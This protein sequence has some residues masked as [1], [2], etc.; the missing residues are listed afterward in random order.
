MD[1]EKDIKRK[2]DLR[3]FAIENMG[4]SVKNDA[5]CNQTE[6]AETAE[7]INAGEN[8]QQIRSEIGKAWKYHDQAS[9]Y[10]YQDGYWHLS[11]SGLKLFIKK[12]F[13]KLLKIF[14][15]WYIFPIYSRQSAFNGTINNS[16]SGL[17]EAE[18]LSAKQIAANSNELVTLENQSREFTRELTKLKNELNSQKSIT[19]E[20]RREIEKLSSKNA[21]L[22]NEFS[23]LHRAVEDLGSENAALNEE[24][25]RKSAQIEYVL[26]KLNISY[27]P[28][29]IDDDVINYFDFEN[30]FR[31]SFE[32]IVERQK[33]Y[34]PYLQTEYVNGHVLDIGFGRGEMLYLMRQ[35]GIPAVGVDFYAPFVKHAADKGYE[36]HQGDALTYLSGCDDDSLNGIVLLQVAEHINSECLYQI[37]RTGYKKLRHGCCF[38]LETPNPESLSTF[39]NFNIDGSHIKPVHYLTMNYMFQKNGYSEIIRLSDDYSRHPFADR[40]RHHIIDKLDDQEEKQLLV[41][42]NEMMFSGRDY[43]IIARK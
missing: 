27:D 43:T 34:I 39:L 13:R 23:E 20:L 31:G 4:D 25:T 24:N 22:E 9:N 8:I 37:I 41:E 6:T 11:G 3:L 36:V 19:E 33:Q 26:S 21:A 12:A 5:A 30:H 29:L 15:G 10:E 40:V 7:L 32:D 35:N 16:V 1:T 2:I 42:I 14:W 38:I 18:S 28:E 17:I